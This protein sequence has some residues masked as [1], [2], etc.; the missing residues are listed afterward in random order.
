MCVTRQGVP[1]KRGGPRQVPRSPPLKHT[2]GYSNRSLVVKKSSSLPQIQF[3]RITYEYI[4]IHLYPLVLYQ[5]RYAFF[6]NS[7]ELVWRK[8]ETCF[9]RNCSESIQNCML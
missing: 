7:P 3:T 9:F 1:P 8:K 4:C 5:I 6:C 2:T